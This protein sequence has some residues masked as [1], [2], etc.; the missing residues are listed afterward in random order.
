[1]YYPPHWYSWEEDKDRVKKR[2]T[3]IH[4]QI[5]KHALI[6][7]C[8]C[9]L[10]WIDQTQPTKLNFIVIKLKTSTLWGSDLC[11]H[12]LCHGYPWCHCCRSIFRS[13]LIP[14]ISSLSQK[15]CPLVLLQ[16]CNSSMQQSFSVS[17]LHLCTGTCTKKP[18]LD[19]NLITCCR[20]LLLRGPK[21]SSYHPSGFTAHHTFQPHKKE[22]CRGGGKLLHRHQGRGGH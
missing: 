21:I 7:L 4:T 9:L 17:S 20:L 16:S 11:N 8:C 14:F 10:L 12:R 2:Q 3:L 13:A 6:F 19:W 1:M 18:T 15:L 5:R 22:G